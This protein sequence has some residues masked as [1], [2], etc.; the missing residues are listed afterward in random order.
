MATQVS[1]SSCND[2][3]QNASDDLEH[4]ALASE[5]LLKKLLASTNDDPDNEILRKEYL[6]TLQQFLKLKSEIDGIQ[7][8]K[9]NVHNLEVKV[10]QSHSSILDDS[11]QKMEKRSQVIE[12][13]RAKRRSAPPFV[14]KEISETPIA[15]SPTSANEIPTI[16][17]PKNNLESIIY[18]GNIPKNHELILL[19]L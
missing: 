9:Q 6:E 4:T 10:R 15:A 12:R 18:K 7:K 8:L 1:P 3:E 19:Y 2:A 16:Q 13:L 14:G 17:S 11:I 5:E